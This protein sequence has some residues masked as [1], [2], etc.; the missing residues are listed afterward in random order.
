MY[1]WLNTVNG[2]RYVGSSATG[3]YGRRRGWLTVLRGGRG[4]N[5]HLQAAWNKYGEAAFQ[6]QTL[7]RCRA[8]DAVAWEQYW[9]DYYRSYDHLVGYN[10]SPTA[11]SCLGAKWTE[12]SRRRLSEACRGRVFTEEKKAAL[13][14]GQLRRWAR[15]KAKQ[16]RSDTYRQKYADPTMRQ[17][18]ADMNAKAVEARTGT[19][20][21]EEAKAKIAKVTRQRMASEEVRQK[22]REAWVRRKARLEKEGWSRNNKGQFVKRVD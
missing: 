16:Q 5:A 6:F 20:H 19:N 7:Q 18:L 9:I 10:I 4:H 3:V 21:T 17:Q 2:K 8:E 12:E 13:S 15:P 14:K 1:C 22:M 11:G